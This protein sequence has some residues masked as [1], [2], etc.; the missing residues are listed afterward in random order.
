MRQ[1]KDTTANPIQNQFEGIQIQFAGIRTE[2]GFMDSRMKEE[3]R[4]GLEP[5]WP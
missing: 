4:R 1:T 5:S 2:F 3:I